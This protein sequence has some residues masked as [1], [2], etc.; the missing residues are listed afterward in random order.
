M[1]LNDLQKVPA[2][3][4][5]AILIYY[6]IDIVL[7]PITAIGFV[8]QL[9]S[10]FA[11]RNS[12]VSGTASAPLMGR[13]SLHNFGTRWDE[14]ASRLMM[15]I[16]GFNVTL[17]AGPG[18]LAH[19]VSGYVPPEFRYPLKGEV[20]MGNEGWHR[21]KFFDDVLDKY[22]PGIT[23][24]VILGAG[25][26][27]RDLRMKGIPKYAPVRSFEVDAPATQAFKRQKLA[28]ARIDSA[29]VAFVPADFE[30]DDWLAQ[31]INAGFNPGQPALFIWEGVT[32]YLDEAA[33]KDT[34][35]KIAGT[36]KGS[37]LAFDYYTSEVLTSQAFTMRAI[38][39]SLKSSGEPLKFGVDA[40]PPS[41]QGL[42]DLLQSCG[43]TLVEQQTLGQETEGKRAW[44]GFAVAATA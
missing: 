1:N 4:P 10:F 40:T 12:P 2:S 5:F 32:M 31:L 44:G 19:R 18:I 33:I 43:L 39:A 41:R 28:Q 21:Q 26:D 22:L 15:A 25:F 9:L 3:S 11:Q 14:P 16:S 8:I 35:R 37:I 36:A 7:F 38:R 13:W 27:T 6:I 34:L 20:T 42:A 24:F 23:Q 30:K 29:G 17:T